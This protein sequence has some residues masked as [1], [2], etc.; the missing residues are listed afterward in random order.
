MK[1]SKRNITINDVAKRAGVSYQTVSRVINNQP[2]VAEATRKRV[3]QAIADLGYQR[4]RVAKNLAS[5]QSNTLGL[6]VFGMGHYG[7]GQMMINIEKAAREAG[8]DLIFSSLADASLD[9]MQDCI[10]I[11]TGWQVSGILAIT[12]V[13]GDASL[14]GATLCSQIPFVQIDIAKNAQAPS[15]IIDQA[16]GS[17]LLTKHLLTLGH[18]RI[19]AITGPLDWFGAEARHNSMVATLAEAGRAPVYVAT[20]DWSIASGYRNAHHLLNQPERFTALIVANDQMALGAMR[21]CQ[22]ND[23]RIP[24]DISIVGFDD[25]P[26]AEFLTPS[27]TTVRQDFD[28]L[29]KQG[30]EYL[31]QYITDPF[32]PAVQQI[33]QPKLIVRASTA[34]PAR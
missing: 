17:R 32:T 2:R 1:S 4:N 33:I 7:P 18:T 24:E 10:N 16:H 12:P 6:I 28:E 13:R 25:I 27:L 5:R 26:E 19:A 31:I 34:P 9:A 14:Q 20:G 22:E 23:L 3:W 29:G 8:Y 15:V 11:L 21:A 30:I